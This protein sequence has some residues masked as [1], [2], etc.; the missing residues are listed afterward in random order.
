M[1]QQK[2]LSTGY[3]ALQAMGKVFA[4]E[5]ALRLARILSRSADSSIGPSIIKIE[6]LEKDEMHA[7]HVLAI[8]DLSSATLTPIILGLTRAVETMTVERFK[9]Q[10]DKIDWNNPETIYPSGAPRA[11]IEQIELLTDRIGFERAVE[12]HIVT[13]LWYQQQFVGR[14]FVG[15]LKEA[16]TNLVD[17]LDIC[18]ARRAEKEAAEGQH[19]LA[20]QSVQRGI[21]AYRRMVILIETSRSCAESFGELK[22]V[23]EEPWPTVT[24]S[25]EL[26]RARSIKRRLVSVLADC[27]PHLATTRSPSKVLPDYFGYGYRIVSNECASALFE[28]EELFLDCFRSFSFLACRLPT[29]LP[30]RLKTL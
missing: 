15:F 6:D 3:Q 24:W 25:G 26:D 13:P 27:M 20:L 19:L 16:I 10:I 29:D 17:Q 30:L 12:G 1:R 2:S 23:P 18:F 8:H 28:D 7:Q 22:R 5:E 14:S 4:V 9:Q 11:V 21:E